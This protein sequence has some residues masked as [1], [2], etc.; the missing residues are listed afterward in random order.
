MREARVGLVLGSGLGGVSSLLE[1]AR[2]TS[3]ADI[4]GMV[5]PHTEGHGGR[6][7]CGGLGGRPAIIL[8]G[9]THFYEG[10][11]ATEHI[12]FPLFLLRSL[13][14]RALI[15]T[16]ASGAVAS[17]LA[18]GDLLLV[19]DHVNLIARN[20]LRELEARGFGRFVDMEGAYDRAINA[21][22]LGA[23]ASLQR[24]VREGVLGAVEG[25]SYETASEVAALRR[26]GI[27]AVTMSTVPEVILARYLGLR[28]AC[29]SVIT[30]SSCGRVAP[31]GL[32]HGAVIEKAS[33][34]SAGL[35]ELLGE[36][37]RQLEL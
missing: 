14:V 33:A 19:R 5:R 26:A 22:L 31:A 7:H 9:R 30:N 28:V 29:V 13:G 37:V 6:V 21:A 11:N 25:P 10:G 2:S 4:D 35:G 8:E 12:A 32:T 16:C 3:Y 20:P 1:G 17:G 23:A 18:A 34:M 36:A 15:L 27:D 24:T